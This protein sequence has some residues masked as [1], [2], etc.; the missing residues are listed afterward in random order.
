MSVAD[1]K[2][3]R[4]GA[5]ASMGDDPEQIIRPVET[6]MEHV[7]AEVTNLPDQVSPDEPVGKEIEYIE[8]TD[9]NAP[10]KPFDVLEEEAKLIAGNPY[11]DLSNE[12][13]KSI[14]S[15]SSTSKILDIYMERLR[16]N[17]TSEVRK[18][19]TTAQ[20]IYGIGD[21]LRDI[22]DRMRKLESQVTTNT[23]NEAKGAD[24][25]V[26]NT[27]GPADFKTVFCTCDEELAADF[28]DITAD[29]RWEE[30]K[31]FSLKSEPR[32]FLTV[33][34]E[35]QVD[36]ATRKSSEW[37]LKPET[38]ILALRLCSKPLALFFEKLAGY[39]AH[40]NNMVRMTKPFSF[41]IRNAT[42]IKDKLLSLT[43][44]YPLGGDETFSD[45]TDEQDK[46]TDPPSTETEHLGS[47][48]AAAEDPWES[49]EA[50]PHFKEIVNFLDRYL[51]EKIRLYS[52]LRA[53]SHTHVAFDDLWMLFERDDMIVC[54]K[55]KQGEY[56]YSTGV[57]KD[58]VDYVSGSY[59]VPQAFR[60]LTRHG[61]VPLWGK[62]IRSKTENVPRVK[63]EG[64]NIVDMVDSE[65]VDRQDQVENTS[66]KSRYAPLY[67]YCYMLTYKGQRWTTNT[68][69]F[70]IK[71]YERLM[72]ITSLEVYPM[73][74]NSR[75]TSG[76]DFASRG[77]QYITYTNISH[78]QY[79][80]LTLGPDYEEFDGPL[81]VD[82]EQAVREGLSEFSST[83]DFFSKV[84]SRTV[85]EMPVVKIFNGEPQHLQDE[86]VV[87]DRDESF[88]VLKKIQDHLDDYSLKK[89]DSRLK[90]II[91][92]LEKQGLIELIIGS[93]TGF[94]LRDRKWKHF[95]LALLQNV[96]YGNVSSGWDDLILPKAHRS[97]VQSMVQTHTANLQ[98]SNSEKDIGLVKGKG[99]G[100]IILLHGVPGVGKTST[101]EC[102]AAYT[103]RPLFPITGGDIG[104]EPIDVE[105]KLQLIFTRAHRWGCVLLIDEADVFLA[106]RDKF[107][108][109]RNGLVSVFLRV[110]EYYSGILFL[111]TNR[112]GAFDDAFRSRIHLT[113]YY[114]KLDEKQSKKIWAM[115]IR[116]VK[117]MN[118]SMPPGKPPIKYDKQ[119][120]L[121]FAEENYDTLRWNGRQIQNAF[122]TALALARFDVGPSTDKSPRIK[123]RHFETIGQASIQFDEY[124][125]DVHVGDETKKAKSQ[126][127]RADEWKS[128]PFR[129]VPRAKDIVRGDW[130]DEV[131][132]AESETSGTDSE[133]EI[134][135][136]KIKKKLRNLEKQSAERLR[137][138]VN[139]Q[140]HGSGSRSRSKGKTGKT[141]H[142][143]QSKKH[144]ISENE[145]SG[146]SSDSDSSDS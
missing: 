118:E 123:V 30:R 131:T 79:R 127:L 64:A 51:G 34:C 130:A 47:S 4:P 13:V 92:D 35:T 68:E 104:Y 133:S 105:T 52:S 38:E 43:Q 9:Q 100:C 45:V 135:E 3:S 107:D 146:G 67:V 91:E 70:A 76:V 77:K 95:D 126:K 83:N 50:L 85:P 143:T 74:E 11:A 24:P 44:L 81:I 138:P 122:Q 112:V 10:E 37:V 82:F 96:D 144:E 101:A 19:D 41:L 141:G 108:V 57:G 26:G 140:K 2:T 5:G 125:Y 62:L 73:T 33:L 72:E 12:E 145:Q 16:L 6:T 69:V 27:S 129:A 28:V 63:K 21:Y 32:H 53:G 31:S 102:V 99:K 109:K 22:E 23:Q 71:P 56:I 66:H 59:Y 88:E 121:E 84:S 54:P 17:A 20:M 116:R 94:A 80:G 142:R 61:G 90:E 132:S 8:D 98:G 42:A 65:M 136:R 39:P 110:L 46:G 60:V 139:V 1:E 113:L 97:M 93:I 49:A 86:N 7:G 106:E 115:N 124:L 120:I 75:K 14:A 114:P 29:K 55:R 117:I 18:V 15:V 89:S 119:R 128:A 134:Q 36:D 40:T 103:G 137:P 111:T 87:F 78:L 48:P 58:A 25:S